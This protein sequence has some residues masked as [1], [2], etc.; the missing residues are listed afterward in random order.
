LQPRGDV[1]IQ[2]YENHLLLYN[3]CF[4]LLLMLSIWESNEASLFLD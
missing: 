3:V 2:V 4:M 1:F